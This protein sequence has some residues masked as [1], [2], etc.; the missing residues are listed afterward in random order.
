MLNAS[1]SRFPGHEPDGFRSQIETQLTAAR[2]RFP[3]LDLYPVRER[4]AATALNAGASDA[5]EL[6]DLS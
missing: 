2:G 3:G 5:S 1:A 6:P 4:F